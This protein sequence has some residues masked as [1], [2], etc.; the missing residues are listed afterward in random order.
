MYIIAIKNGEKTAHTV[1]KLFG[2][3][4]LIKVFET[5]FQT[6]CQLSMLFLKT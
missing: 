2:R 1:K 5:N 3:S 6:P 4:N